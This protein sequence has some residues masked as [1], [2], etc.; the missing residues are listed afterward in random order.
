M[1]ELSYLKYQVCC[2]LCDKD[3]CVRGTS[4][5]DAE[6]WEK[7]KEGEKNERNCY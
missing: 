5:C 3:K 1:S 7:E 2:P 4:E 6:K